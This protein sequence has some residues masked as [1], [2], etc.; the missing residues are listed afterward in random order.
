MKT[1]INIAILA[2]GQGSNAERI[3]SYFS[4]RQDAA[5]RV[6][7]TNNSGA[8]VLQVA[9]RHNVESVLVENRQLADELLS[10]LV[11]REIDFVVLAGF[12][13]IIPRDVVEKFAGRIINVHPAL[14]PKYGG[15]GM[16][17]MRVHE[18]VIAKGEVESG[19]T[20]HHVNEEYDEGAIIFQ[21]KCGVDSTDTPDS[22]ATKIH[23]LEHKHFP[24]VIDQLIQKT[25]QSNV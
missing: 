2:S 17:G 14:L 9:E 13:R 10:T 8:G 5:V 7:I 20:I 23:A 11:D 19:I 1:R 24:E 12:L 6:V 25:K 18:T 4:G 22:L 15:K 21:A 16:Y 3:C